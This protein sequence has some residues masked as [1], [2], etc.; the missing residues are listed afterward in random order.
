MGCL[1]LVFGSFFPRIAVVLIWL[2]RPDAMASAFNDMLLWPLLGVIFLP[3]TTM[4]YVFLW[5]RGGISGLDFIVLICA[6]LL[7]VFNWGASAYSNRDKVGWK[8]A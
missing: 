3:F 4:L 7:D 2:A 1:F 5:A 8:D 6:V